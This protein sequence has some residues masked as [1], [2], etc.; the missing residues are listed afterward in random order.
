MIKLLALQ[1][2]CNRHKETYSNTCRQRNR[3]TKAV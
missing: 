3:R 2:D 1:S